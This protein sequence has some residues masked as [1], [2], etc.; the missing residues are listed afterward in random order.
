[1][2]RRCTSLLTATG[3]LVSYAIADVASF[4]RPGS[5]LDE[6]VQARGETIYFP[7]ARVPLHPPSLSEEAAS[8]LPDQLRPAVLWQLT[9]DAQGQVVTVDV[10][11]AR[12]RSRAQLDY[13]G[14]QKQIDAGDPP[15]A[16]A[17]LARVGSLRQQLAR[18]RHADQPRS[19]RTGTSYRSGT[20]WTLRLREPLPVERTGTPRSP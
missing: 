8:L 11:R 17:L 7:D 18:Q 16:V 15:S 20:A 14:L 10:S 5:V 3:F 12:V 2:I 19:A 6:E 1:M 13:E 4:V 9:L